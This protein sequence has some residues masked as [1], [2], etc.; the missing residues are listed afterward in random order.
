MIESGRGEATEHELARLLESFRP[1]LLR[2]AF[3][4]A[5]DRT[6]AEDVVQETMLRAWRARAELRNTTA[7]RPWLLTIVRREHAR[8]HERK[9]LPTVDLDEYVANQD[10]ALALY[11]ADPEIAD[12]RRAILAL[13]DEY[14]E[15]IVLQ[16]LGGFS[17]GEIASELGLSVPAVLTRLFRARNKLREMYGVSPTGGAVSAEDAP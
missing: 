7:I 13:P 9:R 12:L 14:R 11:D 6:V 3:W 5:R 8:L 16:V 10:M 15:P 17:T 2:F 4:L 1:D